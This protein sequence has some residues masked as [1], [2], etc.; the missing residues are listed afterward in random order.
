MPLPPFH[1][2]PGFAAKALAGRHF[3][4]LLFGLTQVL[5]DLE[6]FY[7][8]SRHEPHLHRFWHTYIGAT[9]LLAL[10]LAVGKPACEWALSLRLGRLR[11]L[12]KPASISWL[13]AVSGAGFGVYSHV[14][15]DSVM[16]ADIRPFAPLTD[17]NPLFQAISLGEL[18]IWCVVAGVFGLMA[19]CVVWVWGK[20]SIEV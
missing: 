11:L 16:H 10:V 2:G 18:H 1:L 4:F 20:W 8:L 9:V 7:Y 3:S 6:P 13:A 12:P 5:I 17:A 19:L 14:L 15:L